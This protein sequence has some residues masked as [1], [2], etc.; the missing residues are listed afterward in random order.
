[1]LCLQSQIQSACYM[2]AF[3]KY[4]RIISSGETPTPLPFQVPAVY[5]ERKD[6]HQR[7]HNT[8]AYQIN[9][10]M[11]STFSV[12]LEKEDSCELGRSGGM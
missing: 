1:M 6:K 9:K 12:G 10:P 5:L 2:H 3:A 4:E 8:T 11:R 7:Q